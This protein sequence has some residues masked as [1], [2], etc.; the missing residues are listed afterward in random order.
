[1]VSDAG[2]PFCQYR[3]AESAE[4][5]CRVAGQE[6]EREG[7]I[8]GRGSRGQTFRQLLCPGVLLLSPLPRVAIGKAHQATVRT[9]GDCDEITS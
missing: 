8:Q 7:V 6:E 1:M 9:S 2:N 5:V 3:V 4:G